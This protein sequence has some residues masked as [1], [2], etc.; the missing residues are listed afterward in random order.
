MRI[1]H[2]VCQYPPYYSG[3]GTVVF[4]M[5]SA[6][7]FLGHDVTVFTPD[8]YPREEVRPK[9]A[10]E[11][12]PH[13][14]KVEA[15]IQTVRRLAPSLKYGNAA[16]LPELKSELEPF[17]IV[18][19][20][21]PF[22]G[23]ANVVRK[24]KLRHPEKPLIVTYH[25]DTR[26]PG[27]KGLLFKYYA[28]FWMPK[29]LDAADCITVS[30]FDYAKSGNAAK[31]LRENPDKWIEL[32]FGVNLERFQPRQKSAEL[33]ERYGLDPNLST[34]L[35]VGGMDVA[36][37]FK[38]IPNLL[39]ALFILKR[40]GV[41]IQALF[42]GDGELREQFVFQAESL[43]LTDCVHFA[44]RVSVEEL[45]LVYNLGDLLVLPS[46]HQGEAFGLV[47]LEAFASGLPVVAT[48]L[49]GVRTVAERAGLL[50]SPNDSAGLAE[51]IAGYFSE[52]TDKKAWQNKARSAAEN[53][54]AWGPIC[55]NLAEVYKKLAEK[56]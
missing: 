56:P 36:H 32:P 45:P 9:V 7:G 10:P 30:S 40:N 12:K 23:T 13:E 49:P 19:L 2:I 24:W 11:I 16:H 15:Q 39:Q 22:F 43:G 42:V 4:E 17:D 21:Y 55:E 52:N 20:H 25:M 54:Y 37:Y 34:L 6:L 28:A 47:I 50:V 29:I 14:E 48:D 35:F 8:F 51:A 33:I 3:M 18:H 31:H 38:G 5:T 27:W 46:I 44:G 53:F 1:A 26:G 41:S